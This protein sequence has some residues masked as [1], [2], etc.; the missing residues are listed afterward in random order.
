MK[1]NLWLGLLAGAGLTARAAELEASDGSAIDVFGWASSQSGGSSLVGAAYDVVGSNSNQGSAY[2]FRNLETASGVIT[3]HVKLVAADGAR[4]DVFGRSVSLSGTTGLVGSV[5]DNGMGSAYIFRNLDTATGTVGH[6]LKLVA[7]DTV[8]RD[9][10]GSSVSLSGSIALIGSP[11][12]VVRTDLIPGSA[13]LFRNLDAA[14]GTVTEDAKLVASDGLAGDGFGSEV[15]VAGA[16]G[17]VSSFRDDF[18]SNTLQGSAYLFRNLD[19]AAGTIAEHAK[20]IASDGGFGDFFGR[21]LGLSGNLAVIGASGDNPSTGNVA[22]TAYLFRDLDTLSG[23]V[24]EHAKLRPADLS[25]DVAFGTKASV[26]GE[27]ALVAADPTGADSEAYAYLFSELGSAT[28]TVNETV[29][30]H[31]SAGV[32]IDGQIDSLGLD[33]D[34]FVLGYGAGDGRVADSGKAYSGSVSSMTTLDTGDAHRSIDGISFESQI[35]WVIGK[36]TDGNEVTLGV[37][38]LAVVAGAGKA[39]YVGQEAGSDG[40]TLVIGGGLEANEVYVGSLAGNLGNTL[41]LENAAT[42]QALAVRLAPENSF[43]VPGDKTAVNDLLSFLGT[44]ELQVWADGSWETVDGLNHDARIRATYS[45]GTGFTTLVAVPEPGI[46]GL[47]GF[48]AG[49]GLLRRKRLR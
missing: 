20:L 44:T 30:I 18:G 24:T 16:T 15:S 21:S 14:T 41:R 3:Q 8:L 32:T 34:Q 13:Y 4:N 10:F 6:D 33:G 2:L 1:L 25:P 36:S 11:G 46:W 12:D 45:S 40:N 7:S 22:G 5:F 48:G 23:T 42:F 31:S 47:A 9:A 19:V 37:G 49:V 39:V 17:L 28:G 27:Q 43:V 38:D 26:S 29:R 35:D